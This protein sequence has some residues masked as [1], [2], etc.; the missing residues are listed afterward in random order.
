[1]MPDPDDLPQP[2]RDPDRLKADMDTWGYCLAAGA[3]EGDVLEEVRERLISQAAAE[4]E[5]GIARQDS[6]VE[7][8]EQVN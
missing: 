2:S 4:R 7:L 8:G 1:M 6:P 5:Q 3:L